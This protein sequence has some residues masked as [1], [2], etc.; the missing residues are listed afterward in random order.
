MADMSACRLLNVVGGGIECG[1]MENLS[2]SGSDG[3]P[4]FHRSV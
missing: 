3:V 2:P 1:Q 4:G